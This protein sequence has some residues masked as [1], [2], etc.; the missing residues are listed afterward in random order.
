MKRT[1][2]SNNI[3]YHIIMVTLICAAIFIIIIGTDALWWLKVMFTILLI[4]V[5]L[6]GLRDPKYK[7]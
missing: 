1:L 7:E 6:L 2:N 3:W 4:G 5:Y